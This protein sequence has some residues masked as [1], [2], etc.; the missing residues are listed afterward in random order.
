MAEAIGTSLHVVDMRASAMLE[1][2]A[3]REVFSGL[4]SVY[5]SVYSK[6]SPARPLMGNILKL[7]ENF[8][9]PLL[10]SINILTSKHFNWRYLHIYS[11]ESDTY[12]KYEI[13]KF[14]KLTDKQDSKLMA[15]SSP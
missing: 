7:V 14:N 10:K 13:Q 12:Y 8:I 1:S 6:D 2:E 3:L 9:D 15:I 5:L 11:I 4:A